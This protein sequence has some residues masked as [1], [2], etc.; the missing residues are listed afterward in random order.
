MLLHL[1][2][3]GGGGGPDY[4]R[5]KPKK[6]GALSRVLLAW[7]LLVYCQSLT[8]THTHFTHTHTHTTRTHTH[9]H[10]RSLAL[11]EAVQTLRSLS[12]SLRFQTSIY[13]QAA[14]PSDHCAI[15][16]TVQVRDDFYLAFIPVMKINSWPMTQTCSAQVFLLSSLYK[17]IYLIDYRILYMYYRKCPKYYEDNI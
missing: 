2:F 3:L 9:T 12:L 13:M 16:K 6:C 17:K 10:T 5:H 4:V 15:G 11:S 14:M 8:H 7:Q 1:F